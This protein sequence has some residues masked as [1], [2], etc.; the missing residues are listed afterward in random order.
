MVDNTFER[1]CNRI[2]ELGGEEAV[3]ELL[4]QIPD[5]DVAALRTCA[6]REKCFFLAPQNRHFLDAKFALPN[7]GMNFIA[8]YVAQNEDGAAVE[9]FGAP[10]LDR[11]AEEALYDLILGE[12]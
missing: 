12:D 5:L 3:F 7:S 10:Y 11:S 6:V 1:L 2:K 4:D 9:I 8:V